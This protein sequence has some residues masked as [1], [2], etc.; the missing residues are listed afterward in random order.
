ME[1]RA[2][3]KGKIVTTCNRLLHSA[4]VNVS[5]AVVGEDCFESLV[6]IAT[7]AVFDDFADVEVLHRVLI[8]G[9]SEL[10]AY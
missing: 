10:A 5:I 6:R 2:Y 7:L 4:I 1:K 9:E 8:S 3:Y